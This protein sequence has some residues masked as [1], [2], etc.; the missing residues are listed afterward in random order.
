M[1]ESSLQPLALSVVIPAYDEANRIAA[2]LGSIE[3]YL[4]ARAEP[5]EILV[6]DD[7]STDRTAEVAELQRLEEVRV[8]RLP[9]N[10]GK[11]AALKA[12]V[13]ASSG[14]WVLLTDADLSTPIEDLPRLEEHR[15]AADLILG[16]RATPE[17]QVTLHQPLYR[18]LMG[19][20]FNLLL[21]GLRLTELRDT[22]C[23]FKL[24]AGDVARELFSGLSIERFAFDVELL[25]MARLRGLTIREVGVRWQN[26]HPSR[27]HPLTDSLRM[28]RDV[29]R[30]R[31][32]FSGGGGEGRGDRDRREGR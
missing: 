9:L 2:T 12:G 24:L 29:L 13:L 18:E 23:G 11:G 26:S 28:L 32:G 4:K 21:R 6:V 17:S 1:P 19:K 22:Q 30:L 5:F 15:G 20:S 14:A 3:A 7:G 31:L 27:V 16:S 10:R 8:L 25:R